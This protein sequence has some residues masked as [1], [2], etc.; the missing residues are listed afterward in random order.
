MLNVC[1]ALTV[2]C[3]MPTAGALFP[4]PKKMVVLVK[5]R[6]SPPP[7]PLMAEYT[8]PL[9]INSPLFCVTLVVLFTFNNLLDNVKLLPIV[10][11]PV[12]ILEAF[13]TLVFNSVKFAVLGN[14]PVADITLLQMSIFEPAVKSGWTF[15]A[16]MLVAD[17][18]LELK[19]CIEAFTKLSLVELR[20]LTFNTGNTKEGSKLRTLTL[21]VLELITAGLK[22][23]VSKLTKV[24]LVADRLFIEAFS[25]D[26][27]VPMLTNAVFL[28][29]D[30]GT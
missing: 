5:D 11:S 20:V 12:D 9:V 25:E 21:M 27:F 30:T 10:R 28:L 8:A 26:M 16:V 3:G 17:I 1:P 29:P 4:A 24:A 23:A 18:L 15:G 13:N 14:I 6:V 7:V 22:K 2:L 19:F